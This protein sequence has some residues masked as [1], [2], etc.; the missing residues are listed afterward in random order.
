MIFDFWFLTLRLVCEID[1][2]KFLARD[3]NIKIVF[4]ITEEDVVSRLVFFD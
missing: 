4:I 3:R 2:R 1:T